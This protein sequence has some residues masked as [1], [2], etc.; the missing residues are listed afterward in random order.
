MEVQRV[1]GGVTAI[2]VEIAKMASRRLKHEIRKVRGD[3]GKTA[4]RMFSDDLMKAHQENC[5]GHWQ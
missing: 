3:D 2:T 1:V 4:S 5:S